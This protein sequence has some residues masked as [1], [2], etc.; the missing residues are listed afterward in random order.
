MTIG[1]VAGVFVL[2][3]FGIVFWYRKFKMVTYF[4]GLRPNPNFELDPNKTLLDQ[5]EELPYDLHWEFP[6]YDVKFGPVIGEG[7]FG[8]VWHAK[9]KG[10]KVSASFPYIPTQPAP[11]CQFRESSPNTLS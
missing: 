5:I 10:I 11:V 9:A 4:D 6:R 7:H 2:T 3:V 1:S 8:K